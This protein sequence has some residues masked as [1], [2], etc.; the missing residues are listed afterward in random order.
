ME[1]SEQKV[2]YTI[3]ETLKTFELAMAEP[4]AVEFQSSSAISKEPTLQTLIFATSAAA[5]K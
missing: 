2:A 5:T 3:T 4:V 1:F